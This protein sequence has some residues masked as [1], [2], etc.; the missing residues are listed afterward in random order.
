MRRRISPTPSERPVRQSVIDNAKL[1]AEGI[2]LWLRSI[3]LGEHEELFVRN[4]TDLDIVRDLTESDLIG[5]GSRWDIASGF[6]GQFV[7]WSPKKSYT[8]RHRL[9][10]LRAGYPPSGG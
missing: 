7:P 9:D 5:L 3:Q 2:G 1:V 6:S 8:A 4:D 10:R